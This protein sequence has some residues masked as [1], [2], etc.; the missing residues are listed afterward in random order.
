MVALD[1]PA[2]HR[3]LAEG[4]LAAGSSPAPIDELV[5]R[6]SARRGGGIGDRLEP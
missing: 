3:H 2:D 1:Q 6:M 4:A 5:S